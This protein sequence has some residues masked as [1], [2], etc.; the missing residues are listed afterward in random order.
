MSNSEI[1]LRNVKKKTSSAGMLHHQYR[2]PDRTETLI[3]ASN[4]YYRISPTRRTL[5]AY[6]RLTSPT[7]SSKSKTR[8]AQ[9][10]IIKDTYDSVGYDYW[11][12]SSFNVAYVIVLLKF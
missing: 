5:P 4:P 8:K 9:V 3:N 2:L 11:S 12:S 10:K 1:K 7:I 6:S